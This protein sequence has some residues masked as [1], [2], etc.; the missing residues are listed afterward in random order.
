M[1]VLRRPGILRVVQLFG[2]PALA[3]HGSPEA[4]LRSASRAV[5]CHLR[6]AISPRIALQELRPPWR[7]GLPK[8]DRLL[9]R[10][11][12]AVRRPSS[13]VITGETAI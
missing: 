8:A 3:G 12:R 7:P 5:R 9:A 10:K 2:H 4:R 6:V 13:V 11:R 1:I